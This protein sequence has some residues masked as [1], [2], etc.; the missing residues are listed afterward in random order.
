VL[1]DPS[2]LEAYSHG[3]HALDTYRRAPRAVVK[4]STEEQV[5]RRVELCA[6]TRVPITARGGGT[7][8]SGACVSGPD[9]IVLSLERLNR[10]I[11]RDSEDFAI[12]MQAGATLEQINRAAEDM[13]LFFPPHPGDESAMAGGM[14]ATN[15]GGARAVKYGTIKRFVLGLQVVLAS[16]Q[17]VELGGTYLKASVG[18]SLL[19]LMIGSEGTLGIITRVML[20]LLPRPGS[21]QTLLAPFATVREA[22]ESVLAILNRGIIPF[23]VEFVERSAIACAERLVSKRW[24]A[25]Q[26]PASLLL[27]LDG[28]SEE[29]VLKQ[30]EAIGELLADRGALDIFLADKREKQE[31]ILR[32][33]SMIYEALR[34]GT[35]ELFDVCVPRSQIAGHVELVHPWRAS[36]R[37]RCRPMG[38]PPTGTCTR[39]SCAPGSTMGSWAKRSRT[40]SPS[41][42]GCGGRSSTTPSGAEETSPASTAS[43]WPKG[44]IWPTTSAGPAS[45]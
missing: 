15:A 12:T 45:G 30:A 42:R 17:I 16:G 33:R 36:T 6:Q 2:D 11:E 9:G 14:V 29:L 22:I 35:A 26:G 10:V 23:A 38:T 27:M 25:S 13:G 31:E 19:D 5:A 40:G 44:T 34:P 24:P 28:T 4:P 18:Y 37:C 32:I 1:A 3:E 39:I 7:G 43:G 21:I 8:L 41:C 20:A